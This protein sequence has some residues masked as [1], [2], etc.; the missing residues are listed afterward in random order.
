ME[1]RRASSTGGCWVSE[2]VPSMECASE[3]AAMKWV[4]VMDRR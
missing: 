4:G 3:K 1:L 2:W